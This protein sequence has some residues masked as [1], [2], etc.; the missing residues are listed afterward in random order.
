MLDPTFEGSEYSSWYPDTGSDLI[1]THHWE[2]AEDCTTSSG[3]RFSLYGTEDLFTNETI[4]YVISDIT[5]FLVFDE[6]GHLEAISRQGPTCCSGDGA[7]GAWWGD[8]H[9]PVSSWCFDN[10][11]CESYECVELTPDD[12]RARL[13]SQR[14]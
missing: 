7:D 8:P 13:E 3:R 6:L 10:P 4:Q 2:A 1:S 5:T 9:H 14:R 11:S 12:I